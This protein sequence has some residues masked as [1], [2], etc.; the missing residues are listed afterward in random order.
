MKYSKLF[1]GFMLL[2]TACVY[3]PEPFEDHSEGD[4]ASSTTSDIGSVYPVNTGKQICNP[5][6]SQDTVNFPGSMLW[7]NFSGK[8]VVDGDSGYTTTQVA[9]HDRL[10][11]SN[12]NNKVLWFL[13]VDS[14]AGECQ[15]QDPE[16][17]TH[18]NYLVALRA[19]DINGS[20]S[21]RTLDYG[22][23]AVRTFD[24]ERFWFYDSDI[25]EFATPHLWV[26]PDAGEVDSSD[27][28]TLQG[29]FGTKNVRLTYVNKDKEIV[30]VD[31]SKDSKGLGKN[32]KGVK[33]KK[34]S[35]RKDWS[36]DSP[37]I[38][39]D[40]NFVVYNMLSGATTWEAYVQELSEDALPV[41]VEQSSGMLSAPAQPHWFKT[42]DRL[43]VEWAEFPA[44]SQMLNKNDL[45][46]ESVQNG[47]VGRTAMRQ[48]M[49]T[50][51]GAL[52]IA[53]EWVGDVR[54]IAPVPTTGGRSPD[55]RYLATGTDLG[56]VIELP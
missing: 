20:A 16:W 24:K 38:S 26:D 10:T 1:L 56:F 14:V 33:L 32:Q 51:G 36:I 7:L 47:S 25:S 40:G 34:P 45:A 48:I 50:A 21:C 8:L 23:F 52:D 6:V 53:V 28:K 18:P 27:T 39:P 43:F 54:E 31:M 55:S 30:F 41:L 2:L 15:F 4:S 11:V 12:K 13:M 35:N 19:Y 3:D 29:F 49:L 42:G 5:S 17:S 22:I 46:K 37:L 9:Q 44:G